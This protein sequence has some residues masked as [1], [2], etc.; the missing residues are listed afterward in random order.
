MPE[1]MFNLDQAIAD[2]RRQM[3]AAGIKSPDV[4]DELESHLR[5]DLERR[6]GAGASAEQA[7]REAVIQ[8]GTAEQLQP[9]FCKICRP[10]ARLSRKTVRIGCAAAAVFLLL[11]QGWYLLD[12]D[13]SLA[14]RIP[15]LAWVVAVAL[16]VGA[17][18][19]LNELASG[20]P[21]LAWRRGAG[22]TC[23]L[24]LLSWICLLYL[25]VANI[26]HFPSG[27]FLSNVGWSLFFAAAIAGVVVSFGTEPEVL[28]L[29]SPRVWQ[30]FEVAAGEASRFRHSFIGTEHLLLGLMQ[31]EGSSIPGVLGRMGVGCETVRAEIEK[32]VGSWDQAPVANAPTPTP[33]ANQALRFAIQEAKKS[34]I[35]CADVEHVF[36]GLIR[37]GS[38]VAGVVLNRLGIN[39]DRARGEVLKELA[40]RKNRHDEPS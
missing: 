33:R 38:G 19:Y 26:T 39:L 36:L 25:N 22:K 28:N 30:T 16:F 34:K 18:P 9:E 7:F 32:I 40:N 20:L 31:A 8:V 3:S 2:W 21:G 4:L 1:G 15:S 11:T 27:I 17:I 14:E 37:E 23:S 29:W 6:I 13:V 35:N 24:V 5:E 12:S 10:H